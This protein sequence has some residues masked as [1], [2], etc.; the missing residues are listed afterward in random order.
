M[1]DS[2]GFR[3]QGWTGVAHTD[4]IEVWDRAAD[5]RQG[6][7]WPA[8]VAKGWFRVNR[9]VE[10][11]ADVIL[12]Q[13][14]V[15]EV[16]AAAAAATAHLNYR[17]DSPLNPTRA[18]PTHFQVCST[19]PSVVA[20]VNHDTRIIHEITHPFEA[21]WGRSVSKLQTVSATGEQCV[22]I[23]AAPPLHLTTRRPPSPLHHPPTHLPPATES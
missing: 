20:T 21:A 22:A 11:V 6:L 18:H 19:Y 16:S 7:L 17:R 15:W 13:R 4:G 23:A 8:K 14:R 12:N 5:P 3:E 9:P 2:V 1:V 10:Q